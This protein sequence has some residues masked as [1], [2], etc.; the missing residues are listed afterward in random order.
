MDRKEALFSYLLTV[1]GLLVALFITLIP[2]QEFLSTFGASVLVWAIILAT[3]ATVFGVLV[4]LLKRVELPR[5]L[6]QKYLVRRGFQN[7]FAIRF[8]YVIRT[9]KTSIDGLEVHVAAGYGHSSSQDWTNLDLRKYEQNEAVTGKNGEPVSRLSFLRHDSKD[10][11]FITFVLTP[12]EGGVDRRAT[13]RVVDPSKQSHYEDMDFGDPY[14]RIWTRFIGLPEKLCSIHQ[15]LSVSS[16][17]GSICLLG[18]GSLFLG[19]DARSSS[20]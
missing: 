18:I 2:S 15:H 5:I 7:S 3:G 9:S 12:K 19:V 8:D 16:D 14:P 13:I 4:Y 1:W 6:I 11:T 10:F 20:S 17:H